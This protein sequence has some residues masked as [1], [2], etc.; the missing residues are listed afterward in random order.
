[1]LGT[2]EE[3]LEDGFRAVATAHP[4]QVAAV[5]DYD[6][7]LSHQ[8]IAGADALLV[9][10]RFEPCGLT[11]MAAMRYGTVPVVSRVGGL[12]DTV[13]DANAAALRS[14]VATGIVTDASVAG[15]ERGL[16]RAMALWAD[17]PAWTNTQRAGMA[18]EFGWEPAAASYAAVLRDGA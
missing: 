13:I 15:L 8:M 17:R 6:E 16:Q 12:A 9:P 10:S 11:Q 1:M 18:A 7:A 4:G 2:G 3:A 5:I 14:G